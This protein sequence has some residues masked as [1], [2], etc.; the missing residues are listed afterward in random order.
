MTTATIT[1]RETH[2]VVDLE[3][4]AELFASVGWH[5]RVADR[6]RLAQLVR[7][8]TYVVTAW[9]AHRL[10]GFARAISDGAFNAYVST[11]AVAP[12]HQ[13]RGIG[14]ALVAR[15]LDGRDHLKFVLHT[16]DAGRALYRALGF[17]PV[18]DMLCRRPRA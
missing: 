11:V 8:S 12:A 18:D 7:G 16:S 17:E 10:V 15:L 3:Q 14:R 4:L 1:F 5:R 13:R 2:D 6:A 9:E